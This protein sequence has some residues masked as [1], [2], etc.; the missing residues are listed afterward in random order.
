MT[1]DSYK[2]SISR[3][4]DSA[5]FLLELK[6]RKWCDHIISLFKSRELLRA[7]IVF[8]SFSFHFLICQFNLFKLFETMKRIWNTVHETWQFER[9]C[10]FF[11]NSSKRLNFIFHA[12]VFEFLYHT[13]HLWISTLS[14][15][16]DVQSCDITKKTCDS[17][18]LRFLW[19]KFATTWEQLLIFV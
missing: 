3:F 14:H 8:I 10:R 13:Q 6:I 2:S 9:V 5:I 19:W 7:C 16:D 17:S 18:S 12:C 4:F 1:R 11:I 15:F